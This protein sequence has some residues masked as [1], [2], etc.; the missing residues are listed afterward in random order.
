[1]LN[2]AKLGKVIWIARNTYGLTK[3]VIARDGKASARILPRLLAR[4]V[5]VQVQG[6]LR[7]QARET[8][9]VQGRIAA[10][11]RLE[12]TARMQAALQQQ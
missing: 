1:M 9:G 3:V 2:A 8:F 5:R 12:A 4:A 10:L 6:A 11:P 7:P